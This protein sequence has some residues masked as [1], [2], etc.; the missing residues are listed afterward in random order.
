MDKWHQIL[1]L[2]PG[3]IIGLTVHEMSHALSAYMLGD[4]YAASRGRISL[5]P[6]RHLSP[7]GTIALAV[8]GVGWARPVMVNP[9]NFQRPKLDFLITSLAGPAANIVLMVITSL[10]IRFTGNSLSQTLGY[11][12]VYGALINGILAV[13]NLL[14]IPPLDGSRIW[15][16]IFPG[17]RVSG[18]GRLNFVWLILILIAVRLNAMN[19]VYNLVMSIISR[20]AG[21]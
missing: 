18:V 19:W 8:I 6:L 2:L 1:Y 11:M 16:L 20:L 7:L 21:I 9:Y 10:V 12:L 17:L 15:P 13:F 5:N 14:P 3:F 4:R